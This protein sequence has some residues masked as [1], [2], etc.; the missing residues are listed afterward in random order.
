MHASTHFCRECQQ[1]TPHSNMKCDY[2]TQRKLREHEAWWGSLTLE[3][4]I[5]ELRKD[6][7]SLRSR[8]LPLG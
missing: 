3:Q 7:K 4:R 5:E 2:C 8:G 1:E 6:I